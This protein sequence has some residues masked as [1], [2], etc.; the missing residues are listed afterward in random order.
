[1]PHQKGG[2]GKKSAAKRMKGKQRSDNISPSKAEIFHDYRLVR[3]ESWLRRDQTFEDAN[4]EMQDSISSL[5]SISGV[6][7]LWADDLKLTSR[8]DTFASQHKRRERM[9]NSF[10]QY[11]ILV[12]RCFRGQQTDISKEVE[13]LWRSESKE[14]QFYCLRNSEIETRIS[15]Y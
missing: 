4:R 14:M 2:R 9:C 11:R 7:C 3:D 15:P 12:Q 1:M 8:D 10:L 13:T 6:P 5:D